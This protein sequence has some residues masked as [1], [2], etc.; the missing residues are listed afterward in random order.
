MDL[1][2]SVAREGHCA[3]GEA[4]CALSVCRKG[5]VAIR[6]LA[7]EDYRDEMELAAEVVDA[8]DLLERWN[9]GSPLKRKPPKPAPKNYPRR[10]TSIQ[11]H[12]LSADVRAELKEKGARSPHKMQFGTVRAP[13]R[14]QPM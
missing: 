13:Y 11:A 1:V 9:R 2:R 5:G 12:G 3:L 8:A 4:L 10:K 7:A 14:I 6:K